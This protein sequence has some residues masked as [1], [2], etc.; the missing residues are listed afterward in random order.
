MIDE[1]KKIIY[2]DFTTL[3]TFKD[4]KEKS[5]LG[6]HIGWRLKQT[7]PALA[8]GH[9][10]HA[11]VAAY[12][13]ALAGG[14][15]DEQGRWCLF[16]ANT[17][18]TRQAQAAFLRDLKIEGSTLPVSLESDEKRSIERGLALVEAYIHRWKDE[19]YENLLDVQGAPYTEVGFK[20][21]L[22]EYNGYTVMYIGYVDKI[23]QNKATG[24]PVIFETKTTTQGLDIY[25]Q[26]CK[27]NHQI[28][29]YFAGIK[30]MVPGIMECIWDCAFVSKRKPDMSKALTDRFWMYGIDIEKDF[31]RQ[32]TMRSSTDV[33]EFLKDAVD[34]AT[35]YCKWKL[36][37]RER[38]P[39]S[40]P[41]ACHKYDGCW[42]RPVCSVNGDQSYLETFFEI[43]PW[44][45]HKRIEALISNAN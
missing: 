39:R 2:V 6:S 40:A 12:Y 8:F 23:M 30:D 11:A 41:G 27:P 37:G 10:F 28:T 16:G 26:Q 43:K 14:F 20:F 32:T 19:P 29:G 33:A 45:P 34:D 18:P 31:K 38:W 25:I 44:E 3:S 1:E 17:S 42:F 9:A 21:P 5:R 35:D 24:R 13:D 36:S 22:I 7:K 15:H 4:C